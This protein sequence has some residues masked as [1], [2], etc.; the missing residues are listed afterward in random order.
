MYI[1]YYGILIFA[2]QWTGWPA[3]AAQKA[4]IQSEKAIIYADSSLKKAIGHLSSGKTLLVSDRAIEGGK[5][6][7]TVVGKKLR[8][9][10]SKDIKLTPK[11]QQVPKAKEKRPS[12]YSGKRSIFRD[13]YAIK[14]NHYLTAS[15]GTFSLEKDFNDYAQFLEEA[16]FEKANYFTLGYEARNPS[17]KWFYNIS[18]SYLSSTGVNALSESLAISSFVLEIKIFFSPLKTAYLDLEFFAGVLGGKSLSAQIPRLSDQSSF[19]FGFPL[20]AQLRFF[21]N[22]MVNIFI[23]LSYR[24]IYLNDFDSLETY[25]PPSIYE[26]NAVSAIDPFLGIS[27]RLF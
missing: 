3:R 22:S 26:L 23:G 20:G 2:L 16:S 7:K 15:Y 10:Q 13:P 14:E 8:Y 21:P 1:L 19:V 25:N 12:E 24:F 9:I 5:I 11:A 6:F 27:V 4:V 17:E 18:A